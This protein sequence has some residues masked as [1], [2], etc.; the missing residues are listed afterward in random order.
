LRC[1]GGPAQVVNSCDRALAV[2]AKPSNND[3]PKTPARPALLSGCD[4]KKGCP[5]PASADAGA[6]AKLP[7]PTRGG[8]DQGEA[9]SVEV[10]A[11]E[12][13]D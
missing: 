6:G 12:G 2:R 3:P 9:V 1:S 5:H 13:D 11:V 10:I 4:G 8:E 7:F